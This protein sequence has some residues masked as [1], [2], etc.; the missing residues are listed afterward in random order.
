MNGMPQSCIGYHKND[1][2]K[3][4][5]YAMA[6]RKRPLSR[7]VRG[8]SEQTIES[9]STSA[10]TNDF[11]NDTLS[12]GEYSPRIPLRDTCGLYA[13]RD[14]IRCA[15]MSRCVPCAYKIGLFD[16]ALDQEFCRKIPNQ[17]PE[18][19]PR[20]SSVAYGAV[21]TSYGGQKK[22]NSSDPSYAVMGFQPGMSVLTVGDGDFSFSLALAKILFAKRNPPSF[23]TS[24]RSENQSTDPPSILIATSYEKESTLRN[25]YPNFDETLKELHRLGARVLYQVDA[26]RLQQTFQDN[27]TFHRICW[28]F[29]CTAIAKGQ[30]GQNQEMEENKQLVRQFVTSAIPLMA[31]VGSEIHICHK[32]KPPF[33]QWKL[34]QVAMEGSMK[35]SIEYAGHVVLDRALLP[36]YIPRKALDRKSF[37]CHDACFYIFL[38]RDDPS[39]KDLRRTFSRTLPGEDECKTEGESTRNEYLR[40]V[41]PNLL[42][43]IRSNFLNGQ[44]QPKARNAAKKRQ[45]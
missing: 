24:D 16:V 18:Q 44:S 3:I 19:C 11:E 27:S 29:P 28:N 40:R 39:T 26:T 5:V 32:T 1:P 10:A 45:R 34:Q 38:G 22:L 31:K 42:L 25:V 14:T 30:D 41:T 20:L 36:P 4:N 8:I 7:S 15:T 21:S 13:S 43:S 37:P 6:N 2:E 17:R 12:A 33:N 9:S 35:L 23:C